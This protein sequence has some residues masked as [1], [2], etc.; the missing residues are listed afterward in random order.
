MT[1][2]TDY[3]ADSVAVSAKK[4]L[5]GE[6]RLPGDK[7][8]SHRAAMIAALASGKSTLQ[9]FSSAE[10][11]AATLSC[12][13]ALSV[14]IAKDGST[15]TIEGVGPDGLREPAEALD[16]QNS[17]T[18]MRLLAGILAGQAFPSTLTG[19]ASLLSRPMQR[20]AE[21]LRLMGAQVDLETNGFAPL[22]IAGR[23]PLQAIKYQLPIA[24][25][26]IK[27]AVLFAG[28]MADGETIVVE[29]VPTRDHTERLLL[30]FGASI[31]RSENVVNVQGGSQLRSRN[32][33]IPGDISSAAFFI[34]AAIALPGSDLT[35]HDVGLNPTRTKF[36]ESMQLIGG[37]ITVMNNR[38]E[39]G[40]PI[41]S[42]RVRPMVSNNR[43]NLKIQGDAVASLIDELPLLA[44]LAASVGCGMELRGAQELRLKESDRITATVENLTRMG[45]QI[46]AMEAGWKLEPGAKLDGASLESFGDHRIAMACAIAAMTAQGESQIAGARTAVAVSLAEFWTLLESVTT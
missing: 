16:A 8:I 18:T 38:L 42:L 17:G 41:G 36:L 10:D 9:N 7:S 27:S 5:T 30:E 29:P 6:L 26:Q 23:R 3:T 22:R 34:A 40:E 13:Q 43:Q 24:S 14:R 20:I 28:L 1:N 19:D 33:T 4:R 39:A 46:T 32:F 35:I 37:E 25:A 11:C 2:K 12:L 21:P 31:E 44:F 45:A 15:V